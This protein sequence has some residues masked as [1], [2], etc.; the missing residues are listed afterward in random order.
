MVTIWRKNEKC[1]Q[2]SILAFFDTETMELPHET[3]PRCTRLLFRL[4]VILVGSWDG[5]VFN[6]VEER[7]LSRPCQFWDCL[8]EHS[9]P[10]RVVWAFAHN[11]LFDLWVLQFPELIDSGVFKLTLP[12]DTR[13]LQQKGKR[14]SGRGFLGQCS[15]D[16]GATIIKG[17]YRGRRINFVDSYNYFRG[18][19]AAIGSSIGVSKLPMPTKDACEHDWFQYCSRDVQVIEQAVTG[20]MREWRANDL[21]N[22]QP[23]IAS[24]A[25][26]SYRHRFMSRPIVAHNCQEISNLEHD[27]YY[28]GRT[29]PYYVGSL[30]SAGQLFD[31]LSPQS[32]GQSV[33]PPQP[34]AYHVDV[35]SLYPS[36]MRG[37]LY[38]VEALSG[39]AGRPIVWQPPS[40]GWLKDQLDT[41]LC[42]AI[43]AIET[44]VDWYPVKTPEGCRYPT[45]RFWTTLCT[46]EVKLALDNNHLKKCQGVILYH[47]HDIFTTWVDYWWGRKRQAEQSNNLVRREVC[48]VLLNSLSGKLAQRERYWRNTTRFPSEGN[49]LSWAAF[50]S[51]RQQ[52]VSLR[53]IGPACQIL[54]DSG[55]AAHSLV[56]ASAHV[57]SYARVRMLQDRLSLPK[58]SCLYQAN[59]G[60]ILTADGYAALML[61][62][63]CDSGELGEYR[64]VGT[65]E[66]VK[67]HGPRD[68]VCD[69]EVRKAGLPKDREQVG[70]RRWE[71]KRFESHNSQIARQPDASVHIYA[72]TVS[73][74]EHHWGQS[75]GADGWLRPI[76]LNQW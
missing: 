74:S 31:G 70:E 10:R 37:N 19:V 51:L 63:I 56:A 32:F 34:P 5:A 35:N 29:A 54:L 48:K 61:S 9:R 42:V 11:V 16:R 45:G 50:D 53:S 57:T 64:T 28:D 71:V 36:V 1:E 6:G 46:P 24:L 15:I 27:A 8:F 23:T 22:W 40:V 69:G 68:Y 73:G 4:G 47:G 12:H 58:R 62:G 44:D 20:L 66:Q 21:G 30:G 13:G 33:N 49:W 3:D 76:R 17:V 67:I 25:F 55:Y 2:P 65:Y 18:G 38:P 41:Y 39:S 72:E 52:P 75:A 14:G 7:Y 60:L 43:C 59:D 26:S